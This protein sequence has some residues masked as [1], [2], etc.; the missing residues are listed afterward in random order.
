MFGDKLLFVSLS[1]GKAVTF[2]VEDPRDFLN[3]NDTEKQ[4]LITRNSL[5]ESNMDVEVEDVKEL[6]EKWQ[7]KKTGKLLL[8]RAPSQLI[9]DLERCVHQ[10]EALPWLC[11]KLGLPLPISLQTAKFDPFNL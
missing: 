9:S 11:R 6:K 1:L 4:R 3:P 2:R 5:T 7:G 8:M 10:P